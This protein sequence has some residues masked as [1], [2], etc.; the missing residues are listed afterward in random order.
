MPGIE[1]ASLFGV[2]DLVDNL[3][4]GLR[5]A[6]NSLGNFGTRLQGIGDRI[7]GLGT[8]LTAI[9]APITAFGVVGVNTASRFQD[10]MAEISARTGIVGED[11]TR[12]QNL[13]LEMGADTAFSAQQAADAFLQLLSSGQTAEEAIATL[14][15]VLDAAAASG[16]DLGRT[17]D[18]VTDIMAAFGLDVAGAAGVVDSLARAA[19]ASSADMASLG[20][21][22]SNVGGVAN[23]F[24]LSVEETA[25]IL[26]IFAENGIKGAEAGTQLRSMLLNMSA[27][28]ETTR[29]AWNRLGTSMYDAQGNMRPIG[30]ILEDIERATAGMSS[31]ERQQALRDLGGAYGIM[32]LTALTAGMDMEDMIFRMDE[33]ASAADIAAARMNTFSGRLDSLKGSV[34]TLMIQAFTPLMDNYLQPLAEQATVIVNGITDWVAANPELAS[35]IGLV[36]AAGIGLVAA[37]IPA[38]MAIGAIG[39]ALGV[40]LSPVGLAIAAIAALGAAYMTNFGGIRDFVDTEVRPRLEQFFTF[41]GTVWENVVKPGLSS[42]YNWFVAEALP[43]I[44]DFIANEVQ[45][46]IEAFFNFLGQ[47]WEQI[48][49]ALTAV[50]AWF[51]E[52]ALP[53]VLSFVRDEVLP[54]VESFFNFISGAWELIEPALSSIAT[55]FTEDAL[56]AIRDFVVNDA[57]PAVN[58][59]L[60]VLRG[61]WEFVQEGLSQLFDW[62]NSNGLPVIQAAIE[63]VQGVWEDLQNGLTALWGIVQPAVQPIVDWFRD[64]FQWIGENFIQPVIDFIHQIEDAVNSALNTLRS[65]GIVSSGGATVNVSQTVIMPQPPAGTMGVGGGSGYNDA[66]FGSGNQQPGTSRDFGG[67]GHAG[68][69]YMIGGG[70]KPELFVPETNGTFIPNIDRVLNAAANG[71]NTNIYVQVPAEAMTNE[72][73]AKRY[74]RDIGDQIVEK[75]R[76]RG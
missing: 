65:I 18:T 42:L 43:A 58:D 19:G 51:T 34:E 39:T 2:I 16:E 41:L 12:I 4:P 28:T 1:V 30:A 14:P 54:G 26:A 76:A 52:D 17:A 55:W 60:D 33:S 24:G 70:A 13:A 50:A 31:E 49:P 57:L 15:A 44:R 22:F 71:G 62:F 29:G 23:Q 3:T 5:N 75:W 10:A 61:A 72:A 11:L 6:D 21:G 40:L 27:D 37:M 25:A 7:T 36:T 73:A 67:F 53:R 46:R 38:G 64:T 45:P 20:Q 35:T 9:T 56:P 47:A 59:F 8:R 32:G 48:S 74:G 66:L 68:E 69:A 63:T